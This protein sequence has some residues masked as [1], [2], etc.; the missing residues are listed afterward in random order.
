M[1]NEVRFTV[2][3][4]GRD[5]GK[6]YL[7]TEFSA[8]KGERLAAKILFA[9][10]NAGINLPKGIDKMAME[11]IA[12]AGFDLIAAAITRIS[13]E[14]AEP[15]FKEMMEGIQFIPDISKPELT[16]IL[17]PEDIE[18]ISTRLSLRREVWSINTSFLPA[19]PGL[20][21]TGLNQGSGENGQNTQTSLT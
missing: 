20:N 14:V 8:E 13:F 16:R 9:I 4:E 1:R 2:Q 7:I 10:M 3:K 19:V 5:K 11:S 21:S 17:L 12:V 15:I 6:T 18:E